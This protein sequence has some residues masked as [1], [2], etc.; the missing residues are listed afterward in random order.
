M[1]IWLKILNS[2]VSVLTL[3]SRLKPM[4]DEL[5]SY[6]MEAAVLNTRTRWLIEFS[7]FSL[8]E[9]MQNELK[10][11]VKLAKWFAFFLN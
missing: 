3:G 9:E 1:R 2:Y 7:S 10:S 5:F 8:R 6:L 4:S 11:I